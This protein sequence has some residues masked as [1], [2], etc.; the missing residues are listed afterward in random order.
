MAWCRIPWVV[1]V[2]AAAEDAQQPPA[3]PAL[4]LPAEAQGNPGAPPQSP[5]QPSG[6]A[7]AAVQQPAAGNASPTTPTGFPYHQGTSRFKGVS[8]S[9]RSK[10]WRAQ[11]WFGGKVCAAPCDSAVSILHVAAHLGMRLE[12]D[13]YTRQCCESL[14]EAYQRDC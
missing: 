3:M 2:Q 11:L 9:E 7:A 5:R 6:A 8:W 12:Y 1:A 13:R 4:P 10:K 14:P